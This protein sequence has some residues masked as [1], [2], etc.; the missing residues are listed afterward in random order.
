[1]KNQAEDPEADKHTP[2]SRFLEKNCVKEEEG[3][4]KPKKEKKNSSNLSTNQSS[5]FF[6]FN[7]QFISKFSMLLA[8]PNNS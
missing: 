2:R 7:M 3:P 6:L 1:M 8:M 5:F 4:G